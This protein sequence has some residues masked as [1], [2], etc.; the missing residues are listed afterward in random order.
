MWMR[1]IKFIS[2]FR[3]T[4]IY[5][6]P[7]I[8]RTHFKTDLSSLNLC[9]QH[10]YCRK[11]KMIIYV[12][13]FYTIITNMFLKNYSFY[14]Y[15]PYFFRKTLVIFYFSP[16]SFCSLIKKRANSI[17]VW[18]MLHNVFGKAKFRSSTHF[19]KKKKKK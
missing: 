12:V 19:S 17:I 16:F 11:G 15:F 4:L 9:V 8:L 10:K 6:L 7:F 18:K 14:F 2:S 5:A 13:F 3:F 1:K